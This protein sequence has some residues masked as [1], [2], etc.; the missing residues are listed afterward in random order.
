[1]KLPPYIEKI[2]E[3]R[4]A[5][6]QQESGFSGSLQILREYQSL[7]GTGLPNPAG[8]GL[9][10][11]QQQVSQIDL[12]A[13]AVRQ[14]TEAERLQLPTERE[15]QLAEAE[16]ARLYPNLTAAERQEYAQVLLTNDAYRA[17]IDATK[18]VHAS[19]VQLASG[20]RSLAEQARTAFSE[21]AGSLTG[22]GGVATRVFDQTFNAIAR[23][24]QIEQQ[25]AAEHQITQFS[26]TKAT[27]DG[28][29]QLAPVRAIVDT[30]KGIEALASFQ[31]AS[32]AQWFAAAALWG[33]VGAF[34]IASM[35]GAFQPGSSGS[36]ASAVSAAA[37]GSAPSSSASTTPPALASGTASAQAAA[38]NQNQE[39]V[40]IHFHGPVYGGRAGVQELIQKFNEAVKYNRQQLFASHTITGKS[41]G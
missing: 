36:S 31:W 21:M 7:I 6:A 40:Q 15:L 33:T 41:L 32:A 39:T 9:Q 16:L 25:Q 5:I 17:H 24:I 20:F 2:D 11:P 10:I 13:N 34:Q 3:L 1:M 8:M 23:Q 22:W 18:K 4:A 38:S 29:K 30:A 35:A 28:I 26:M 14:L 12:Q 19:N 27:L 37:A